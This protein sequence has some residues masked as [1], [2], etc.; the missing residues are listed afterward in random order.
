MYG[1]KGDHGKWEDRS[2]K[3]RL[4]ALTK[5]C[6]VTILFLSK[7]HELLMKF[8]LFAGENGLIVSNSFST[9]TFLNNKFVIFRK[10]HVCETIIFFKFTFRV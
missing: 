1:R 10:H 9:V 3:F 7:I 5:A 6:G 2:S 4:E 8:E